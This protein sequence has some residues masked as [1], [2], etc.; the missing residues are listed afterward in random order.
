MHA[1]QMGS[2]KSAIQLQSIQSNVMDAFAR[3]CALVAGSVQAQ[4][5]LDVQQIQ[6]QQAALVAQQHAQAG[7]AQAASDRVR[8]LHEAERMVKEEITRCQQER[9][10]LT[11]TTPAYRADPRLDTLHTFTW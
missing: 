7:A 8:A 1:L 2:T 6:A 10:F 4:G 3:L 11:G 9:F 5:N